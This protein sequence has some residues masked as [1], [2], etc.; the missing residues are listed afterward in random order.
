[1]SAQDSPAQDSQ[2]RDNSEPAQG[3]SIWQ[4]CVLILKY[5]FLFWALLLGEK[6]YECRLEERKGLPEYVVFRPR[7]GLRKR[8][9][10]NI[11]ARI[12]P[13]IGVWGSKELRV[14]TH[15]GRYQA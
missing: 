11:E 5:I 7:K 14:K 6:L 13:P 9:P 1:M 4:Y 15:D 8:F 2:W 10:W 12:L 3:R